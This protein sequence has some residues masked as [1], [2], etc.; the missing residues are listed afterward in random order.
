MPTTPSFP[1]P[2]SVPTHLPRTHVPISS[3]SPFPQAIMAAMAALPESALGSRKTAD[4]ALR[5][6]V[7]EAGV[8]QFL[9][10]NLVPDEKRWCVC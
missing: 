10:Q 9:L 7:A 4:D 1:P 6:T 2:P 8:R 3:R 5:P